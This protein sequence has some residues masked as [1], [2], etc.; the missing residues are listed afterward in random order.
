MPSQP[1]QSVPSVTITT[2]PATVQPVV[3]SATD[4]AVRTTSWPYA[5]EDP[6]NRPEEVESSL[7]E[8]QVHHPLEDATLA[9]GTTPLNAP[10]TS[11]TGPLP[12]AP[13]VAIHT[14][15][16]ITTMLDAT[17]DPHPSEVNRTASR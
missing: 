7:P 13:C 15:P 10:A 12:T 6:H 9:E 17:G 8:M 11:T 16:T 3:Q 2:P 4:V 14:A 5:I 1:T